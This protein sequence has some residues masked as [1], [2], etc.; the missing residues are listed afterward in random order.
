MCQQ[1]INSNKQTFRALALSVEGL[2]VYAKHSIVVAQR[3][4]VAVVGSQ[5]IASPSSAISRGAWRAPAQHVAD[6]A[7]LR[8][9]TRQA[10]NLKLLSFACTYDLGK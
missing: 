10:Q 2:H 5:I 6:H 8:L 9:L 3:H 1:D 7:A 4:T